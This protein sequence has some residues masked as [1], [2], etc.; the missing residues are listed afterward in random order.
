MPAVNSPL[1][2]AKLFRHAVPRIVGAVLGAIADKTAD[3]IKS[4]Q[5]SAKLPTVKELADF[6]FVAS[7]VNEPVTHNPSAR[8]DHT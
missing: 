3:S 7:P 8:P 6:D 5:A 4:Q 1:M 2:I